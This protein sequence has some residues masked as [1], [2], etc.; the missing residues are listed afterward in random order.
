MATNQ[1]TEPRHS[2]PVL[3][4]ALLKLRHFFLLR[5][6][7][8]SRVLDVGLFTHILCMALIYALGDVTACSL[9]RR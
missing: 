4:M 8:P 2:I 3:V 1:E 9:L 5:S 6:P 7:S